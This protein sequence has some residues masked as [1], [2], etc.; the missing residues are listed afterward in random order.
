MLSVMKMK[1]EFVHSIGEK[2]SIP[3][4]AMSQQ[5]CVSLRGKRSVR[6]EHHKGILEYS[7]ECVRLA[8]HRGAICIF[9]RELTVT[10]M[11][12]RV[13]ELSGKIERV[14]LE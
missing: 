2:L 9:G 3:T 5:P 8:V 4:E 6:V 13:M 12:E 10:R 7:Q 1:Q 14:E 11:S